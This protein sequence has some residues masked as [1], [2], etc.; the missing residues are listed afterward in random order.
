MS[1]WNNYCVSFQIQFHQLLQRYLWI[2]SHASSKNS[3]ILSLLLNLRWICFQFDYQQ[4]ETPGS[5][6][7]PICKSEMYL[8]IV[9]THKILLNQRLSSFKFLFFTLHKS[10]PT[11]AWHMAACGNGP[12]RHAS[13][14]NGGCQ[15]DGAFEGI[16]LRC[17]KDGEMSSH[18]YRCKQQLQQHLFSLCRTG[19]LLSNKIQH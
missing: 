6:H 3:I 15:W 17:E 8:T 4:F 7:I 14:R 11:G 2:K 9:Q 10:Q 16:L 13:C 1:V 18:N 5:K 19:F 12:S